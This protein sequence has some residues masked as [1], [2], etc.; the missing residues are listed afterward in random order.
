M[1][2]IRFQVTRRATGR[3]PVRIATQFGTYVHDLASANSITDPDFISVG[4]KIYY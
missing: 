4:Q 1:P 2:G 3:Y